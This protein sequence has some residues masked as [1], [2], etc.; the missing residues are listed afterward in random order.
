MWI[1]RG[2]LLGIALFLVGAIIFLI[3][4]IRPFR[5]NRAIGL[6]VI[7]SLTVHN[8]LFWLAF[9]ACLVIGCAIVRSWPLAVRGG[10]PG[11]RP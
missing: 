11:G 7:S 9:L 3:A 1:L 6:S 10:L 5:S 2:S 4:A 8:F